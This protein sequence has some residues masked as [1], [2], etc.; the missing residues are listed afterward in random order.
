MAGGEDRRASRVALLIAVAATTALALWMANRDPFPL[1]TLTGTLIALVAA[2]AWTAWLVPR[3]GGDAIG[4]TQTTLGALPG[5]RLPLAGWLGLAGVTLVVGTLVGGVSGLP[6]TVLAAIAWLVPPALRRPGL[7]AMVVIAALYAPLLGT[8]TLWDPWE[9]HYGEVAREILAR[10]DWISLWWAQDKWF[11]SK[12]ALLFWLEAWTMGAL[13]IDFMPDAN[14]ENLEWA[15]RLPTLLIAMAA[16]GAVYVTI[17]RF[18]DPRAGALAAIVVATMPQFFFISHQAIT[19]VPLVATIT[20]AACC[21]LVAM[22]EDGER[23]GRAVGIGPFRLSLTHLVVLGLLLTVLPQAIYLISRNFSW[24]EGHGLVAHLDR[25]LYGSA[26]N[27]D[28]PGNPAPRDQGPRIEGLLVQPL[29]QGALWLALLA[30][31]CWRLRR[32]RRVQPLLMVGFYFFCALAFMAKGLLGLALPGA[33]ALFYLLASGR[34]SLLRSGALRISS[35]VL[36]V[37]V[38]SLP[39]YVAMYV[40][41]G[42]AFTNRLLIHDHINRLAAGVHGDKGTVA[43]FVSQ[44]GYATFPWI[45]LLPAALMAAWVVHGRS[46]HDERR[47]TVLYLSMWLL[48]SFVLFSAMATKYHHYILPALVPAGVLI[49]ISVA[50]WWG[51]QRGRATV[52]AS[53]AGLGAVLGFAWLSGDLRGV[54]PVAAVG[55]EDWVLQQTERGYGYAALAISMAL[56]L[57]AR[58]DLSDNETHLTPRELSL[59]TGVALLLGAC[60]VAFVGRDLSWATSGRPQGYERLVHL[61]V[62]NYN[63][64]WPVHLDYR[65]ILTGFAVAATLWTIAAAFRR[66]RSVAARALVAVALAFCAWG[67]DVYMVDVS[68]HWGIRDLAKRYY[69]LRQSPSEPLVAWQ[70]NWKGENLYTGNRVYVFAETNNERIREWLERNEGAKVFFV[71]EHKR[72]GSFKKLLGER[73]VHELSNRRENNKFVLVEVEI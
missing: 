31:L 29:A 63:R 34:W 46:G 64:T 17:R 70:M 59:G 66:W 10:N 42:A 57:L 62:Y 58:R 1:G 28:V 67:L 52:L 44:L 8:T 9:T 32:E 54:I 49:G 13:G 65:P 36:V 22:Q 4:W 55:A 18:F 6:I 72:L 12:P 2:G 25:F 15:I 26:G 20:L 60:L 45:A 30:A 3:P 33:S 50:T 39:W 41:H 11:W 35:G 16:L 71:L 37:A 23:I 69:T 51:P 19:D 48:S 38:V 27:L 53:L 14:P 7:L 73:E 56:A 40:R 21:L 61:F 5:E 24:I 47:Q 68:D 43:Y